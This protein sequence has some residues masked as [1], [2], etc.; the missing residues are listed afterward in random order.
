MNFINRQNFA[1][2]LKKATVYSVALF[3]VVFALAEV[4]I[5]QAFCGNE[6][7]GIPP[8]H[9]I[10]QETED[11][12]VELTKNDFNHENSK[13]PSVTSHNHDTDE[14][15]FGET[16]CLGC[17][18]HVTISQFVF[19]QYVALNFKNIPNILF[20]ENNIPKSELTSVFRPPQTA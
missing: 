20:Y 14:D 11:C 2:A 12:P 19:H 3:F 18:S 6:A 7:V 13:S 16:E 4:S 17:C 9:H 10:T 1:K 5:L 8:S 15:C